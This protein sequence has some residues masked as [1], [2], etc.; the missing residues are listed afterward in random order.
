VWLMIRWVR[1]RM[2]RKLAVDVARAN[3]QTNSMDA[4]PDA[5]TL[6]S[7]GHH[8]GYPADGISPKDDPRAT[9]AYAQEHFGITR[10][11]NRKE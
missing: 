3:P 8:L 4:D 9:E 6:L 10:L 11:S 7:L 1:P 2:L 5:W